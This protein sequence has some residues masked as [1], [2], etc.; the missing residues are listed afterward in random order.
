M[1]T[2]ATRSLQHGRL[3]AGY[4][5]GVLG[6]ASGLAAATCTD[7]P[8]GPAVVCTMVAVGLL[9]AG[10]CRTGTRRL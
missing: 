7:L 2:L 8:D 10:L 1:P 3:A 9:F 4:A 6:Y 5:I